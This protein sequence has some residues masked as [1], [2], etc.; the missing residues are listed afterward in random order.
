MTRLIVDD[1][2][3]SCIDCDAHTFEHI[4]RMPF[5]LNWIDLWQCRGCKRVIAVASYGK[6]PSL[7]WGQI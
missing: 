7:P 1:E 2:K 5:S 3:T 4:V 6:G